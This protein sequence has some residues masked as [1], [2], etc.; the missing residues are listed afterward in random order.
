MKRIPLAV[1]AFLACLTTSATGDVKP[2]LMGPTAV[3]WEE[4]MGRTGKGLSKSVFQSPTATLDE[5]EMHITQLPPGK[6][7]HPPHK[8]AAE[9]VL[10]IREGTLEALVDGKTRRLGPGSVIFQASNQLHSVKNVGETPAVY[11]VMRWNSPGMLKT[12]AAKP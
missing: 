8:H 4:I 7:P 1:F 9:E 6:A 10:I 12:A 11:Y 2:G 3:S 5:L